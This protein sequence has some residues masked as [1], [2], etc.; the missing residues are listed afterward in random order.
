[1]EVRDLKTYYYTEA[2]VVRAVD[3]VSFSLE[4]GRALG[5]VGESGCGKTT[6][7]LSLLRLVPPP[8]RIVGGSI[9]L[10]GMDI[11][12]MDEES[13][14]RIR[15]KR[16]ALVFQGAMN[17][18]N[19]VIKVGDQIVEAITLHERGVERRDAWRRA[20][21]LL[22]MVGIER[23]RAS[24]YPFEFSGG[25]RQRAVLAMALA[26]NPDLLILDEPATALDVVVQAQ[27]IN[28]LREL[29]ERLNL[30]ML[31]ITHDLSLVTE[32]C[33]DVAVMYAGKLVEYGDTRTIY[34]GSKHPYTQG[35]IQCF[36]RVDEPR[37]RLYSIP[38]QPPDLIS[39]P[40]GCR[41][42]PRCPY[43]WD[44]CRAEEPLYIEVEPAH[45]AACHLNT[46]GRMV[47]G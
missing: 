13:L 39:P 44:I 5:L 1:L 18:L 10:D 3:G 38:G 45:R 31:L 24:S 22:E 14:R 37:R 43:A 28:L 46:R 4:R 25:M 17:A 26:L 42:H 11:M 32:V 35:L 29:R 34:K 6:V 23:S 19:P 9:L 33:H 15:W 12:R 20:E 40:P 8:G 27:I 21:E 30:T 41:F 2:G 36:P 7:A 47:S 16:I